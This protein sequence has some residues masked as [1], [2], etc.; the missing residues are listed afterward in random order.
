MK[1]SDVHKYRDKPGKLAEGEKK[2]KT[3]NTVRKTK[4]NYIKLH[5]LLLLYMTNV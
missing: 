5:I 2:Q 1:S 4:Q 3:K